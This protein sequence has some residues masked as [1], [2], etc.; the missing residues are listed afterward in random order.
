MRMLS[1]GTGNDIGAELN[2]SHPVQVPIAFLPWSFASLYYSTHGS[3]IVGVFWIVAVRHAPI[4]APSNRTEFYDGG[5]TLAPHSAAPACCTMFPL[6]ESQP[7]LECH[8]ML[9]FVVYRLVRSS[10]SDHD[11]SI[12][13]SMF[14]AHMC[15]VR[16][17]VH[18]AGG[19]LHSA[20]LSA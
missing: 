4:E 5:C 10:P 6:N 17:A 20:R 11:K 2:S 18:G 19:V 1:R 3:H 16:G 8:E 14:A 15:G 12:V 13:F 9:W 7:A